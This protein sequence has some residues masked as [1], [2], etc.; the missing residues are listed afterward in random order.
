MSESIRVDGLFKVY[1]SRDGTDVEALHEVSFTVDRGEFV[2]IVG[3]SGCG[4]STLLKILAAL[5][6]KTG[7]ELLVDGQAVDG[8]RR[9][10]GI[11]FQ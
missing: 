2:S 7:G 11:V 1:R 5:L 4:K 8:H 9:D 3:Q 6:P 10:V